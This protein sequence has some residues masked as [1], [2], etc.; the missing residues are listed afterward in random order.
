MFSG[1]C[2]GFVTSFPATGV[3]MR[4][5]PEIVWTQDGSALLV[6]APNE[7]ETSFEST[8]VIWRVPVNAS[9]AQPL[10]TVT[11]ASLLRGRG[12]A[13]CLVG[14]WHCGDQPAFLPAR[15][16]F[17]HYYGIPYSNDMKPTCMIRNEKVIDFLKQNAKTK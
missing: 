12:Y 11:V 5:I 10:A 14:K 3:P 7:S 17:D 16:G 1:E 13:T 8:V 2:E 15:H 9:P 4:I 6:A